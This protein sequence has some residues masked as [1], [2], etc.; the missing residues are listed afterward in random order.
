M[1]YNITIKRET[2][3]EENKMK[4]KGKEHYGKDAKT[5]VAESTGKKCDGAMVWVDEN[6]TYYFRQNSGHNAL[7]RKRTW[8]FDRAN[9]AYVKANMR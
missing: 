2:K 1:F 4:C 6:G 3:R 7:G 8:I 5:I 9:Q